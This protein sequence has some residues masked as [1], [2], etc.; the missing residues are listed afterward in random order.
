M[1]TYSSQL[2]VESSYCM[3]CNGIPNR[4]SLANEM[5]VF[6]T[7]HDNKVQVLQLGV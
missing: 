2:Q 4:G 3:I 1:S 7:L 5:N 6:V